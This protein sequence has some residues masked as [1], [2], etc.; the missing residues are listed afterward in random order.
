MVGFR[1]GDNDASSNFLETFNL[2]DGSES[3]VDLKESGSGVIVYLPSL[4]TIIAGKRTSISVI[5]IT[6][7]R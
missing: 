5:D 7:A 1:K 3:L 6:K 4:S 2:N